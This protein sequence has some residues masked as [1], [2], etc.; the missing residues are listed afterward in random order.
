MA[1]REYGAGGWIGVGTP[2]ANPTVEAEMRRMF[3]TNVELLTTRLTSASENSDGRWLQYIERL[4][5]YLAAFDT[6]DL[7]V[8]GFACTGS[9]YLIGREREDEIRS[10][11][12]ARFGYPIITATEAVLDA[13]ASIGASRIALL[14]P[15]PQ[16][17]IDASVAYW[18]AAGLTVA[19]VQRLDIGSS[20]T[21]KI[22][23]LTGDDVLSGLR[24]AN[25]QNVDAIVLSGTGMPSLAAIEQGGREFAMPVV[26]SNSCLAWAL[27][28]SVGQK[29]P[30]W[31]D[32]K[33][34]LPLV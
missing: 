24:G 30:I 32:G 11:A 26:S 2:Q 7:D 22:Y 21:R 18:E 10:A 23:S 12:S 9:S 28:K 14:A 27:L 17:L 6:L 8:F 25:L 33:S 1:I 31:A 15:Y 4:D 20:D 29:T 3:P 19:D 5:D 13:L 34:G 16:A